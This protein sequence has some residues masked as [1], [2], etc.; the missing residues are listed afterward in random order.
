VIGKGISNNKTLEKLGDGGVSFPLISS[1]QY[2]MYNQP[3]FD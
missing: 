1:S 2:L 3:Q